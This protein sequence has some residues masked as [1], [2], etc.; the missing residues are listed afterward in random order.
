MSVPKKKQIVYRRGATDSG[1]MDH[2]FKQSFSIHT[3][4]W[5]VV[6][7]QT[8]WDAT[9]DTLVVIFCFVENYGSY[10][11]LTTCLDKYK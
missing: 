1:E 7:N 8:Q 5:C 6:D 2:G 3:P 11:S 9:V 4:S 10:E